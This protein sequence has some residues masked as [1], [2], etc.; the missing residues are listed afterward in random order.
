MFSSVHTS[1]MRNAKLFAIQ[2]RF[3]VRWIDWCL[4]NSN[5]D[6]LFRSWSSFS[7]SVLN[8]SWCQPSKTAQFIFNDLREKYRE[9]SRLLQNPPLEVIMIKC[10]EY[11]QRRTRTQQIAWVCRPAVFKCYS[12]SR[13]EVIFSG[14]LLLPSSEFEFIQILHKIS[15]FSRSVHS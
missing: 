11:L 15:F 4:V 12:T 7:F 6:T 8:F 13:N 2:Y 10:H 9:V 1:K 3:I 5:F 14:R